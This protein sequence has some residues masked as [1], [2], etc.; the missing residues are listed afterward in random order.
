[1]PDLLLQLV[2]GF[3]FTG[4]LATDGPA[5]LRH[6]G[7]DGLAYH[8]ELVAENASAIAAQIGANEQAA[9]AAGWLHDVSQ[10]LP[11]AAMVEPA[12]H[13]GLEVLP[14]ERRL[15]ML[16]HGKLSAVF[17]SKLFGVYDPE[18]LDAIRCHTT[19][20]PDP[21]EM[22]QILFVADKLSW[23]PDQAPYRAEVE[24]A[25]ARSLAEAVACFLNWSWQQPHKVVHPWLRDA[26]TQFCLHNH[27][28]ES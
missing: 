13:F 12:V 3:T 4:A 8:V 15:P 27:L 7:R 21:T 16:L 5:F 6:H 17:A 10:V 14:E 23:P 2:E 28:T 11:H 18:V 22:D 25:L 9:A 26:Y 20:R 24:R 19:L 1:M